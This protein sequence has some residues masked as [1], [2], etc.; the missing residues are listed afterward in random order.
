ME[1]LKDQ[2]SSPLTNNRRLSASNNHT[3][4][5]VLKKHMITCLECRAK[6]KTT[7]A[8]RYHVLT[9]HPDNSKNLRATE[10]NDCKL[11]FWSTVFYQ[12]H[13]LALHDKRTDEEVAAEFDQRS[14]AF[15]RGRSK[16]N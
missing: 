15:G 8:L 6:K 4:V 10:C 9:L 14:F 12:I 16:E 3:P 1:K 5:E 2:I 7:A 11:V 13:Y